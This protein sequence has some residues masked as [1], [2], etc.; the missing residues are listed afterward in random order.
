MRTL[1]AL[2]LVGGVVAIA[3]VAKGVQDGSKVP[4]VPIGSIRGVLTAVQDKS[5]QIGWTP[6]DTI[7]P[8]VDVASLII[9]WRQQGALLPN[10]QGVWCT[11]WGKFDPWDYA[12]FYDWATKAG[13]TVPTQA[14]GAWGSKPSPGQLGSWSQL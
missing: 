11:P 14:P 6:S 9:Y 3:A 12:A 2:A 1:D 10:A 8:G 5:W 13:A 7:S 4:V